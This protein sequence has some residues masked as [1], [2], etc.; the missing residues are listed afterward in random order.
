MVRDT[1]TFVCG[2]GLLRRN[3]NRVGTN[4]G[5]FWVFHDVRCDW[6]SSHRGHQEYPGQIQ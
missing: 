3:F 4:V 1:G 5:E 2:I 6:F